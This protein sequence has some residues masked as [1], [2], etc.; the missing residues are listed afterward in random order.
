[1]E[2]LSVAA[3][4]LMHPQYIFVFVH[5]HAIVSRGHCTLA[6]EKGCFHSHCLETITVEMAYRGHRQEFYCERCAVK[7]AD[8]WGNKIPRQEMFIIPQNSVFAWV[9]TCKKEGR[10][11][12]FVDCVFHCEHEKQMYC[13]YVCVCMWLCAEMSSRGEKGDKGHAEWY[14]SCISYCCLSY[15]YKGGFHINN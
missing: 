13:V 14:H 2:Y 8:L 12:V 3:L 15:W 6:P 5:M 1:M 4:L 7:E 10:K 9:F 11:W